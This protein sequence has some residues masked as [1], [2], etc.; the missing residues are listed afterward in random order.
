[1]NNNIN[2]IIEESRQEYFAL[3]DNEWRKDYFCEETG[4]YVATH[5][6]KAKDV[7]KR[8]GIAKEVE[9]CLVLAKNGMHILRL[10]ENVLDKIDSI[11]VDEK[12][13][14]EILK[15]KTGVKTPKGYPDVYFNGK[16]WDF[17]T[18]SFRKEDTL[19]QRIKDGRKAD[20]VIFILN[21]ISDSEMVL[22]ATKSEYG[23]RKKDG[24]WKDLPDVYCLFEDCLW[25]I[26]QK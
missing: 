13:Y 17:K 9:S 3:P 19:R 20:N 24:S 26:G 5:V 8:H 11:F 7:M 21:K 15:F 14:R 4:G 12:P 25:P 10:P 16:T 22:K 2:S 6:L 23:M 18:S 1:M